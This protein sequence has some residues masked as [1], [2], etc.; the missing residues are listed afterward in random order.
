MLEHQQADNALGNKA[1]LIR[2]GSGVGLRASAPANGVLAA[3][4]NAN[5]SRI[6]APIPL[7]QKGFEKGSS[8]GLPF[9]DMTDKHHSPN[10]VLP[11]VQIGSYSQ[12]KSTSTDVSADPAA[13]KVAAEGGESNIVNNNSKHR[14]QVSADALTRRFFAPSRARSA[15]ETDKPKHPTAENT[16]NVTSENTSN[17]ATENKRSRS[18]TSGHAVVVVTSERQGDA[19]HYVKPVV[20]APASI[21][22]V[23][24]LGLDITVHEMPTN[25]G[26]TISGDGGAFRYHDS[27]TPVKQLPKDLDQEG[28]APAQP[29]APLAEVANPDLQ[30]NVSA[31]QKALD[32]KRQRLNLAISITCYSGVMLVASSLAFVTS[33]YLSNHVFN[34]VSTALAGANPILVGGAACTLGL[35]VTMAGFCL[36]NHL[37]KSAHLPAG[38]AV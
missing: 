20:A 35:V 37:N 10:L 24:E 23:T 1:E 15:S 19:G 13:A 30:V 3:T 17:V 31:K 11:S 38:L 6:H 28:D 34:E 12:P 5:A 9:D 22:G 16:S 32:I 8:E 14:R 29:A 7:A 18:K 33:C 25:A 21:K 36:Q 26:V 27:T 4:S 2:D